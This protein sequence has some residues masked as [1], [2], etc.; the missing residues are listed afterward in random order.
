MEK[1]TKKNYKKL[2]ARRKM[3]LYIEGIVYILVLIFAIYLNAFGNM[4]INMIPLLFII[5]IVGKVFFD[6]PIA[7]SIMGMLLNIFLISIYGKDISFKFIMQNTI[8][9]G[10]NII[11]G[12]IIGELLFLIKEHK[13]SISKVSKR[14]IYI[15]PTIFTVITLCSFFMHS[16]VNGNFV[17]YINAD[18]KVNKYIADRYNMS[19][20]TV[21]A[22]YLVGGRGEYVFYKVINGKK[23]KFSLR[24]DGYV[25][26][27][28]MEV[29]LDKY[30]R[31]TRK[32]INN[33]IDSE[34]KEV[35]DRNIDIIP[36]YSFKKDKN[37][38]DLTLNLEYINEDKN[39]QE[40]CNQLVDK[41]YSI[42]TILKQD[43]VSDN[44]D[45]FVLEIK[46]KDIQKTLSY[47]KDL[48][49]SDNFTKEYIFNS[50]EEEIIGK[51]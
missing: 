36:N 17:S 24:E 33:Y 43:F 14:A 4:Y 29:V 25:E 27:T 18:I 37:K 28:Y 2:A 11:S 48:V 49:Y 19:L 50:F 42:I 16:Y 44:L 20:K 15:I 30:N 41:V 34:Y 51:D 12:E 9:V 39:K 38:P 31:A 10:V 47:S 5:G 40:V 22:K 1:A 32:N 46:L 7:T 8:Y 45:K 35:L 26:D 23:Y 6:R 3:L 13:R 21:D